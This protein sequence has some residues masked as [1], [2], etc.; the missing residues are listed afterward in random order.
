MEIE[1]LQCHSPG[2]RDE[3]VDY[4][5][6]LDDRATHELDIE[7]PNAPEIVSS[8]VPTKPR[9]KPPVRVPFAALLPSRRL[10][11]WFGRL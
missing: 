7:D 1:S 6:I 4:D 2:R 11:V 9:R 5:A 10:H 3:T 8:F